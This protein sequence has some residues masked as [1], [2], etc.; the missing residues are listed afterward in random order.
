[1]ARA[2][3]NKDDAS[4]FAGGMKNRAWILGGSI[5]VLWG[6]HIANAI[7]GYRLSAFGV[8][9]RS[10]DGL[11]GILF[12]PLL[13]LGF[14]HLVAN[15]LSLLMI[16][17]MVM[18]RRAR[19][20]F[21][22][23]AVSALI[24]GLGTWLIGGAN[25]VH[26][27]ASG[28]IFG[29]LGYLLSRGIF[30]RKAWSIAVSVVALVLFG[31]TLRGLFPGTAGISW[32]GHLFGFLGG[33]LAARLAVAPSAGQDRKAISGGKQRIGVE[34][35]RTR[36]AERASAETVSDEEIEDLRRRMIIR[37]R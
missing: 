31:G 37:Q 2:T 4:S 20:F 28:V 25:T 26:V 27:G 33:I 19:D 11:W 7:V 10:L 35:S 18:L 5:A 14:G 17:W 32:E 24:A 29:F 23:S 12:A 22:V 36:I 30:E 1:M 6:I 9:P 3:G 21:T 8:H 15:T 16:G 13:H 34:P